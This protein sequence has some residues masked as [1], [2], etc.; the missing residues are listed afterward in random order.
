[1]VCEDHACHHDASSI[2]LFRAITRATPDQMAERMETSS[3]A[4]CSNNF[5]HGTFLVIVKPHD[6]AKPWSG[7][8]KSSVLK[9]GFQKRW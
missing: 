6:Q 8:V 5:V 3:I 4:S 2:D 7:A 9:N 1:M